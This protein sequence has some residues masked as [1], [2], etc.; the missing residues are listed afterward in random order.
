MRVRDRGAIYPER[1][2]IKRP[3][4]SNAAL[5]ALARAQ[6]RTKSELVRDLLRAELVGRG[7]IETRVRP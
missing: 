5:D 6:G 7:L 2:N 3:A 4:G 1:F